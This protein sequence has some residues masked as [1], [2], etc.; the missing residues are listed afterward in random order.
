[1]VR[2]QT[3]ERLAN[4]EPPK[5]VLASSSGGVDQYVPN[6]PLVPY[7]LQDGSES[8]RVRSD[9][10]GNLQPE[11]RQPLLWLVVNDRNLPEIGN[12]FRG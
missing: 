2:M 3:G 4:E 5:A 10:A 6:A 1:M 11:R 8:V 7:P 12:D 9:V